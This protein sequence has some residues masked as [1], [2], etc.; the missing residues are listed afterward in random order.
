MLYPTMAYSTFEDFIAATKDVSP[1]GEDARAY[2][3]CDSGCRYDRGRFHC[4]GWFGGRHPWQQCGG[5]YETLEEAE[6]VR[7]E[8]SRP[9]RIVQTVAC[10]HE[11]VNEWTKV[12]DMPV[13]LATILALA[14]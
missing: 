5:T 12:V 8:W 2:R 14:E 3:C 9:L 11:P 6:E 4:E 10:Y 7:S 1:D 13:E